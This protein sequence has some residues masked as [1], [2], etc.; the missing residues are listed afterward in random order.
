MGRNKEWIGRLR[1]LHDKKEGKNLRGECQSHAEGM[2]CCTERRWLL[3]FISKEKDRSYEEGFQKG[4]EVANE[5]TEYWDTTD[6]V[7]SELDKLKREK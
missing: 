6:E 7:L 4:L 5:H 2:I 1:L 3:Y